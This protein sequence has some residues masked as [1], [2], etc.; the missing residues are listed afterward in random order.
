[1]LP[2]SILQR[3]V[4]S[5]DK[6]ESG[7]TPLNFGVYYKNTL[8]ALCHALEDAVLATKN[9]AANRN[10]FSERQVVFARG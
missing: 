7:R 6:E 9:L 1:M 8:V 3:L 4:Q 2:G 10:G 5:R